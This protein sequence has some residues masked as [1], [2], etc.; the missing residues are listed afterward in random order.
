ML[1]GST[2]VG[3]TPP[4]THPRILQGG[5][6]DGG[7]LREST[8]AAFANG[9]E[10]CNGVACAFLCL[11]SLAVFVVCGAVGG[12]FMCSKKRAA[13]EKWERKRQRMRHDN[14]RW[15]RW[16]PAP[17]GLSYFSSTPIIHFPSGFW[18][19][20][21]RKCG[22]QRQLRDFTLVAIV[23][24]TLPST[25][26]IVAL[27]GSGD[28]SVGQYNILGLF[29]IA[30][31]RLVFSK[32]YR[33]GTGHPSENLG[34]SV[35]FKGTMQDRLEAGIRGTWFEATYKFQGDGGF[36]IW[37]CRAEASASAINAYS[38]AHVVAVSSAP[39]VTTPLLL[40][41]TPY[42]TNA[43]TTRQLNVANREV[44]IGASTFST[45]SVVCF[46]TAA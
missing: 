14:E 6:W 42:E 17:P 31:G 32:T 33:L 34:H 9:H 46:A 19:G 15:V 8:S 35:E 13:Y 16:T 27:R 11:I 30:T 10:S 20:N 12:I 44:G 38:P 45:E 2:I 22:K 43:Y 29:N 28:D 39:R 18:E 5:P 7:R 37:P 24:D 25:N 36:H 21:Y 3:E 1:R 4:L 41:E 40:H 26:G 23:A